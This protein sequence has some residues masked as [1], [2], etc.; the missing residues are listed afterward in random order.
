MTGIL[1]PEVDNQYVQ[2]LIKL[3]SQNY[4]NSKSQT[5]PTTGNNFASTVAT[6]LWQRGIPV[7]RGERHHYMI[8][9]MDSL[10]INHPDTDKELIFKWAM[11]TNETLCKPPLTESQMREMFDTQ[12]QKYA[13]KQLES[14]GLVKNGKYIGTKISA[15]QQYADNNNKESNQD[16]DDDDDNQP[17]TTKSSAPRV[18][19]LYEADIEEIVNLIIEFCSRYNTDV[20]EISDVL[21]GVAFQYNIELDSSENLVKGLGIKSSY[22]EQEIAYSI[23]NLHDIYQKGHGGEEIPDERLLLKILTEKPKS[24]DPSTTAAALLLLDRIKKVFRRRRNDALSCL[25][26][27]VRDELPP[28][29]CQELQTNVVEVLSPKSYNTKSLKLVITH[30]QHKRIGYA[31]IY[32]NKKKVKDSNR[33]DDASI[34]DKDKDYDIPNYGE[35]QYKLV[36]DR[37]TT[38]NA[39]FAKIEKCVSLV[40]YTDDPIDPPKYDIR[41]DSP[42]GIFNTGPM[43]IEQ[44]LIAY[45]RS[46][47]AITP[48]PS[49]PSQ[50][51]QQQIG[52]DN[53]VV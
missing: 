20:K 26:E 7:E 38:I 43:T 21:P 22:T 11:L 6:R 46:V 36:Y 41:L 16:A 5:V 30:L 52:Q 35:R 1:I 47:D 39:A 48:S 53:F 24:Q 13:L 37:T 25:P 40:K 33:H 2:D 51:Q 12:C 28:D 42:A 31:T 32:I 19:K 3:D 34:L 27:Y 10:L 23:K 14:K 44:I 50:S 15:I 9:H 18:S 29:I 17:N 49:P 45:L 4:G 8:A